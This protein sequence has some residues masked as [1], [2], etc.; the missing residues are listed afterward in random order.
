MWEPGNWG[1][2]DPDV[3]TGETGL[4]TV[5]IGKIWQYTVILVR[6][7]VGELR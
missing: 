4:V 3:Y 6:T 7:G 5:D 1:T 2:R